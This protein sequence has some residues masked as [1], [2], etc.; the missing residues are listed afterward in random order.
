M[1]ALVTG[2]C[3]FAASHLAELL[4]RE[5][6]EVAGICLPGE[7]RDN[8]AH[9]LD[10]IDLH[11]ADVTDGER[12]AAA[13]R[14]ARPEV[15]YHLAGVASVGQAWVQA[16]DTLRTNALGLAS[17]VYAGREIGS[18]RILV[19]GS[20]EMYG[21]VRKERQPIT[22][23]TRLKP[24]NPYAL[25]KLWQEE[26]ALYFSRV[27]GYPLVITRP[28]NHTGPRQSPRFVCSDFASQLAGIEAGLRPPVISVGNLAA[29]RDFLHVRDVASAY[30]LAAL[31]GR[32]G[33]PYNIASG[34]PTSVSEILDTLRLLAKCE[35]EVREEPS[36]LRPADIPLLT[37]SSRRLQRD[38]GWA[39]SLALSDALR[40]L[41]E[42]WRA[43]VR[44]GRR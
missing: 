20:G 15:V 32:T 41:L 1:R 13:L 6:D 30:R 29:R 27:Y 22:E 16:A 7:P 8:V 37:G 44:E 39:P 21:A 23:A 12:T 4:L 35:V 33:V 38:T 28:F 42:W 40:E 11:E 17:L 14:A 34:C 2:I 19:V 24:V 9:L 43:R 25:S 36:R 18:P 5:G 26:A 3:G 31:E 10:R